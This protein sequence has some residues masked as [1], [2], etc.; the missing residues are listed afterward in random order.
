MA[1]ALKLPASPRLP[2]TNRDLASLVSG[3]ESNTR[4]SCQ[5]VT[6]NNFGL[7]DVVWCSHHPSAR[8]HAR[9]HDRG[10]A[11]ICQF[12]FGNALQG[13]VEIVSPK[14]DAIDWNAPGLAEWTDPQT[15]TKTYSDHKRSGKVSV[16]NPSQTTLIKMFRIAKTLG[17]VVSGDDGECCDAAGRPIEGSVR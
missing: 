17:C 6:A 7:R 13:N 2:S 1:Q 15:G 12:G 10:V 9:N 3:L 14:G 4:S 16:G 5:R 8:R 11:C